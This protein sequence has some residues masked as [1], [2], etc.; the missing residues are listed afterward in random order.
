MNA[1]EEAAI[2]S[3]LEGLPTDELDAYI[4]LLE[5][6]EAVLREDLADVRWT[7]EMLRAF[8]ESPPPTELA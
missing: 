3:R 2:L 8:N 6:H 5:A 4:T 7:R 1:E